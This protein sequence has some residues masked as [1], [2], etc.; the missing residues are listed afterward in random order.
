MSERVMHGIEDL[1]GHE[2]R[3]IHV[4]RLAS[5]FPVRWYVRCGQCGSNWVEDHNRVRYIGCRNTN[6][7]R[8]PSGTRS[9]IAQAVQGVTAVRSRD[10]ESARRFHAEQGE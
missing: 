10:S 3:G 1:T 4:E 8:T 6:C 2:F 9:T 5:R 7:G